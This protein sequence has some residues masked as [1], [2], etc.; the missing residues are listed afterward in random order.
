M[1]EDLGL[2]RE[3]CYD[4]YR[5]HINKVII[6]SLKYYDLDGNIENGGDSLNVYSI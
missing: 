5:Q 1:C 4:Y 6:I 3:Y 2:Y